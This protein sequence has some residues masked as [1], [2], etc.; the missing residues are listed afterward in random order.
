MKDKGLSVSGR[1]AV[2]EGFD[3]GL[4]LT[5]VEGNSSSLIDF[6]RSQNAR[7]YN[8]FKGNDVNLFDASFPKSYDHLQSNLQFLM[9]RANTIKV[10][11]NGVVDSV[12]DLPNVVRRAQEG[13]DFFTFDSAGRRI[14]NVTN[15]E[16][17]QVLANPAYAN[18]AIFFLDGK[19][20]KLP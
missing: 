10:N 16:I 5:R 13:I 19:Q 15:W 17:S 20:V 6:A 2:V 7:I 1:R 12:G 9:D 3:L 4:G 18:K 11:L 8:A 14:G